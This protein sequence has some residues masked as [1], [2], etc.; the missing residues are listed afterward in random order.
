MVAAGPR[1]VGH[2]S[3]GDLRGRGGTG[4]QRQASPGVATPSD[5]HRVAVDDL[6]V[7]AAAEA[8]IAEVVDVDPDL[9]GDKAE[10][11]H[12]G[13]MG[14]LLARPDRPHRQPASRVDGLHDLGGRLTGHAGHG[15]RQW[16]Q[17]RVGPGADQGRHPGR[18]Q[19]L[20]GAGLVHRAG[21][22]D[23]LM[24]GGGADRGRGPGQVGQGGAGGG[25]G[26]QAEEGGA[27]LDRPV[28]GVGG[29]PPRSRNVTGLQVGADRAADAASQACQVI[30]ATKRRQP[31]TPVG[32]GLLVAVP[33]AS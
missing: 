7:G 12:Q 23:R 22:D 19:C 16:H 3:R 21:P 15:S 20:G 1:P 6:R 17:G 33:A 10:G 29:G 24:A 2:W 30:Q 9:L 5:G 31:P 25:V 26:G 11:V 32:D 18:G 14:A 28:G 13:R 27:C 8:G 4:S